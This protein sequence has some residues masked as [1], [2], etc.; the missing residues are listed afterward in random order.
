MAA[1]LGVSGPLFPVLARVIGLKFTV[2]ASLA[3]IAG[4]LWQ[5]SAVSEVTTT[6]ADVVSGLLL[7]GLGAG[8]LLPTATDSVVGSVPQGDSGM[9]SAP[10][11]WRCRSAARS[12][13][14]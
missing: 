3:A 7:V 8:L 4:G 5:V 12:G 14:R 11:P 13:S 9:G 1:V 10:T 6:Y 2:A